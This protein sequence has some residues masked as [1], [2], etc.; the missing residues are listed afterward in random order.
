[1]YSEKRIFG[2]LGEEIGV[3]YLKDINFDIVDRN[4]LYKAGEIDIVAK[5][6]GVIHFIEVKTVRAVEENFTPS[7][8]S[9]RAEDNVHEKKLRR[10]GIAIELYLAEKNLEEEAWVF[11]VC[12]VNIY[13]QRKI[14]RV[15]FLRDIVI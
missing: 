15:K 12:I 10:I 9:Y 7:S 11:D 4:C 14:A 13:E 1:M 5:S 8:S 2:N 6:G 3:R